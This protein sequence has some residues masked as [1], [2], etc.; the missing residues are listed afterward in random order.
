M[1]SPRQAGAVTNW[2]S[3]GL[4]VAQE[5]TVG[6]G[7]HQHRAA[8]ALDQN[9]ELQLTPAQK[10]TIFT[11]IRRTATR[12]VPPPADVRI[13]IGAEVPSSIEL[14]AFPDAVVEN[15]PA[16]KPY[17]FTIVNDMLVL[18]DPTRA[19]IVRLPNSSSSR[20][21]PHFEPTNARASFNTVLSAVPTFVSR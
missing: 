1:K 10:A 9:R 20:T 4:A 2:A 3:T 7:D 11:T 17:R 5:G 8:R 14:Y 18:I 6:R 13:D 16:V 12:V 19:T 21:Y 15:L